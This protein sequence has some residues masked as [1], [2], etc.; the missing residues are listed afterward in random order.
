M[1]MAFENSAVSSAE[2]FSFY[3]SLKGCTVFVKS[4]THP[5]CLSISKNESLTK[6]CVLLL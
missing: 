6:G 1:Q 2:D 3:F 5:G 4:D